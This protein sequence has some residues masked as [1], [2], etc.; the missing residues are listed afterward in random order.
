MDLLAP[1]RWPS[2]VIHSDYSGVVGSYESIFRPL[3]KG[4]GGHCKADDL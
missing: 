2:N 4:G 1:E 3:E